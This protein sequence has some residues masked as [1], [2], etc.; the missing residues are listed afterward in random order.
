MDSTLRYLE[1]Q[2]RSDLQRK[3]VFISGPRQVGK[4][5]LAKRILG[6]SQGYLNWDVAE[7]RE[8]ILKRELPATPLWVLDEIHK[9]RSWR[10]W[11]KGLY[12]GKDARQQILVAG[13][14]KLDY[15]RFGG[16]SLQ[17]R[18]HHLRLHP[19]SVAE[20]DVQRD[21]DFQQLLRL[22]GYPEPFF[23]GSEKFAKRWSREH[24]SLIIR[25]ELADLERVNDLGNLE[26]LAIRL[27]EL[28]G[29]PLSLNALR[30]DLQVSHKTVAKWV[31]LLE[32]LYA[33][34]RLP[35]FGAPKLRAVKKEQKHYHLDWSLVPDDALRF[36]NLVA[37]HLLKWVHWQQDTEGRDL[38]LRYFRDVD[39][40]EVDFVV[41]E[42]RQ[43]IQLIECKWSDAPVSG[44]L[45][46]LK[47]RFPAAEALQISAT[48]S[49]DFVSPQKIRVC[50]AVEFLGRLT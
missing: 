42:R 37:A 12:D 33:L 14:A 26:L 16:D 50:P 30:E 13:S 4:T 11:L 41:V 39:R 46:Y 43:P 40:R 18:Y 49:K 38:E 2:A 23:S 47:E 1:A 7:H 34:F 28:V 31:Q 10:N 19:L 35:P 22:G 29:S 36:E 48:G 20:L 8:R 21:A 24:R 44:G 5:T 45:R 32:R 9:Y 25:E 27:P 17:G 3:M 15:Y 6:Q